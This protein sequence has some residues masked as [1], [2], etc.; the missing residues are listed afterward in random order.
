[1]ARTNK[2]LISK[3]RTKNVYELYDDAMTILH[4]LYLILKPHFSKLIKAP[5]S[6]MYH[7]NKKEL[8]C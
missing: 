2:N 6:Y 4:I 5:M 7:V 3:Q 8:K 1:M